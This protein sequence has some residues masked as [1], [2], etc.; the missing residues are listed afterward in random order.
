MS[1]RR[2]FIIVGLLYYGIGISQES[3]TPRTENPANPF[4]WT[5]GETASLIDSLNRENPITYW[6]GQNRFAMNFHEVS[7]QNW[8][9]GGSNSVALLFDIYI[10]RTYEKESVRWQ[11]EFITRYGLSAEK[12]RKLRKTDDRLEIGSTFGYR[13]SDNSNWFYSAKT[14]LKT[15]LDRGYNYPDR[16]N[17]ISTFMA[18]GYFFFG[19][20]AEYG[21]DSDEFTLYI[22]PA[23][24]KTTFVLDQ[25]LADLGAFGVRE[26]MYDGNGIMFRHG[27]KTK[28]EFGALLTSEYHEE[29][30][31]NIFFDNRV[32]LYTDYIKNFGNIDIDWKID[33]N[34]K[35]NNYIAAKIGSHLL[36]N[37]DTKTE[38]TDAYGNTYTGGPKVQWM[39]E[40]GIGVVIEI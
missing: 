26:A 2:I 33:L 10:K 6:S 36:F 40:L 13:S 11:N 29:I 31:P 25:R 21:K 18:P 22:S 20:G 8:S 24:A 7:F 5:Y 28:T 37:N 9:A 32:S 38:R 16:E 3:E 19:F 15:Q 35:V 39:Q 12:G 17:P 34:L 30:L 14:N 1:L 23:T 27:K 4:T